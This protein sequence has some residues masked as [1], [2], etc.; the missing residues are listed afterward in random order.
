MRSRWPADSRPTQGAP[1]LT[2]PSRAG[3]CWIFVGIPAKLEVLFSKT[4]SFSFRRGA[5]RSPSARCTFNSQVFGV[6]HFR[7]N[8]LFGDSAR[9][10]SKG[11]C[12]YGE[13][14]KI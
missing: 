3:L 9:D 12:Y 14:T 6:T 7:V 1:A 8:I 11:I 13:S 4:G 10:E 2:G 5:A